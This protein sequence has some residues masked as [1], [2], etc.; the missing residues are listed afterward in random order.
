MRSAEGLSSADSLIPFYT[1][2]SYMNNSGFQLKA[3]IVDMDGVLWRGNQPIGD[4]PFIFRA[5]QRRDLAITLATNN[6][7]YTPDQYV[8]KVMRFGVNLEPRQIVNSPMAVSHYLRQKHPQGGRIYMIGEQGLRAALVDNGFDIGEENVLAVVVGIDWQL[9][10]AKLEKASYLINSGVPFIGTNP[11][12][13]FPTP[14]G[15]APGNGAILAA[16]EAATGVR[17]LVLGKPAPEMYK[18]AMERMATSP[19]E[20]MV[21]GDRLETDIL[22]AQQLGCRTG[23]VLSGVSSRDEAQFWQPAPDIIAVDLAALVE[24][25]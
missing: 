14:Q 3:L 1:I 20:T 12:K 19:Q 25:I 13:T 11:D 15:L 5:I 8:E 7:T 4:L 18:V 2:I 10:Y 17:P 23:L 21:I 22:G 16:I 9:T 24:C 6:A